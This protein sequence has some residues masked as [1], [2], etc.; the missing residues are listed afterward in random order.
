MNDIDF[1]A[2]WSFV[3][4]C[5]RG[6]TRMELSHEDVCNGIEAELNELREAT[7]EPSEHIPQFTQRQEEL[8]DIILSAATELLKECSKTCVLTSDVIKAKIE[9]NKQRKD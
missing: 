9:Y 4:A 7:D 3:L 1:I 6:K 8:A 5:K 2:M